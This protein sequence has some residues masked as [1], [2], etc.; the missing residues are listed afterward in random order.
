M[1]KREIYSAFEDVV[2]AENI[3]EDP[4]IL[5]SYTR[6]TRGV[7]PRTE[8]VLLPK[9]T[10][11]V[12][13]I[14]KL[15]NRYKIQFKA[16]STHWGP[17]GFAPGP[18]AIK[19]DLRRMN[20]IL[21]INEKNMYAV[22]E[23]YVIGAQLQAELMKRGLNCSVTGAGANCSALPLAA[24]EGLGHSCQ[25]MSYGERNLLA[26]EWVAPD[27][28]IIRFGSLGS[29]GDWSCGDG[30]GPSL[31]GIIRGHVT[32]LG[33]LGV[34]TRAAQKLYH[35]PGPSIFP[36]EGV[37]PHYAPNQI[38]EGFM[39]RYIS[40]P[41]IDARFEALR[42]IGESEIAFQVMCFA[43][44]MVAA[45]IATNNQEDMEYLERISKSV[46][47][48]GLQI[49]VAGNSPRD[50]EYK[51]R[52]LE[53]IMEET[54]GKSLELMED[55]VIGGG[56][57]WRCIRITGSIRET[58][59]A[60]GVFGGVLGGF[61]VLSLMLEYI[62]QVAPLKADLMKRGLV[63]DDGA[64]PFGQPVEHGHYGHSEMLIRFDPKFK[65][66]PEALGQLAGEAT[67]IAFNG[68]YG[69]LNS[70]NGDERHD[71]FGPLASNYHLW[72]RGIKKSFDPGG[73][74]LADSHITVKE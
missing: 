18:N 7:S 27:G 35:W 37:S 31:R 6:T 28:E 55:P 45:N 74:S 14:V 48:P 70:I 64:I 40:F 38:P 43:P 46:Q 73:A 65:G 5:E 54:D 26:V 22:V 71:K 12:Q 33:G 34:F 1:L 3:S 41:S 15:C 61:D 17:A 13:A 53:Q 21:E 24:H 63:L 49:I 67:N 19:M 52:A 51:K 50:F 10:K 2:G 8:A 42:K 25:S 32:P 47:G 56:Q 62:K 68:K 9:E 23:P 69:V 58:L 72:L 39:I 36:I 44:S 57:L 30:P 16:S 20:R 59:R 66:T 4:A 29:T 11:E 60:T